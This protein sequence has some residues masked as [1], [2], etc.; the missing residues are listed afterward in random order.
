MSKEKT[1]SKGKVPSISETFCSVKFPSEKAIAWSVIVKQSRRL[2]LPALEI[3][4]ILWESNFIP[5][6]FKTLTN[7]SESCLGVKFF[8]LNCKHLDK[9]VEGILSGSVVARIK[10]TCGGGSSKVFKSELKLCLES[11][12]TS[13]IRYT[14]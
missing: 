14:L 6:S 5:S 4:L 10:T 8:K 1:W 13:S 7:L 11:M 9:T 2:P 12:C 3:W